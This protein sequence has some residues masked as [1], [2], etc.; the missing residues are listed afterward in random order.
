MEMSQST[1]EGSLDMNA[2][3]VSK[4]SAV[5]LIAIALVLHSAANCQNCSVTSMGSTVSCSQPGAKCSVTPEAGNADSKGVC[6]TASKAG[7]ESSCGCVGEKV[8]S[9]ASL[10]SVAMRSKGGAGIVAL[11]TFLLLVG[12]WSLVA[13]RRSRTA[14]PV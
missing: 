14:K 2:R 6:K 1:T 3:F 12:L 5:L 9:Q 10:H 4:V 8:T 11:S 13:V 7:G